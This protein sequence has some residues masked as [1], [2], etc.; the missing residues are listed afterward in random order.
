M[1]EIASKVKSNR[2]LPAYQKG[3]IILAFNDKR[4]RTVHTEHIVSPKKQQR[5]AV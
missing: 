4:I 2:P 5:Y 3:D 1:A